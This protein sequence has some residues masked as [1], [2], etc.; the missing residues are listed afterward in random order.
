MFVTHLGHACLLVEAAGARVVIDPGAFSTDWHGLTDLDAVIVT[1]VHPDH[2]DQQNLPALLAANPGARVLVEPGVVPL[3]DRAGCAELAAGEP[4]SVAGLTITPVGGQHAV[5]H[6]DLP[7]V[8]NLGVRL[9]AD[10]EPTL[11]HPGD[12]IEYTPDGID[13][14]AVPA[15]APWCAFKETV[16]FT[17]AVAPGAVIPIHDSLLS[18]VGRKLYLTQLGNLGRAPI[19][20]LAGAGRVEIAP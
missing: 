3:L 15:N 1:H 12:A 4:V 13:V 7:R 18:P 8:G 20:D 17:R 6:G 5:I 10:G 11:M 19:N 9:S 2:I 16:E 14:L